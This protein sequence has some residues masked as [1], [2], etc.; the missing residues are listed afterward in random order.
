ML[1]FQE[2]LCAVCRGEMSTPYIDHDHDCCP[3]VAAG[4][5]GCGLCVRGLLC[6][7]CNI[8]LGS[9]GDRPEILARAIEYLCSKRFS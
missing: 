3:Q 2:G 8:M 6:P 9:V 7:R 4:R 1:E 5:R